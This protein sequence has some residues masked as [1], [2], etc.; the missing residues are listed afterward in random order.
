MGS[1]DGRRSTAGE[2]G[3]ETGQTEKGAMR[4]RQPNPGTTTEEL[5][6]TRQVAGVVNGA[7]S[8]SRAPV[9]PSLN[10]HDCSDNSWTDSSERSCWVKGHQEQL[11]SRIKGAGGAGHQ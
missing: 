10:P 3:G 2:T 8:T 7:V 1:L 9:S 11:P 5:T 6:K 4:T